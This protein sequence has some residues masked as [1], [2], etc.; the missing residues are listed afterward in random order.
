MNTD[1]E[2]VKLTIIVGGVLAVIGVDSILVIL[3]PKQ[4][5]EKLFL[6]GAAAY[7]LFS[8]SCLLISLTIILLYD[9]SPLLNQAFSE[10]RLIF[11]LLLLSLFF[12]GWTAVI[13]GC[14]YLQS[15]RCKAPVRTFLAYGGAIKFWVFILSATFFFILPDIH[16]I[17]LTLPEAVLII[18]GLPN[19]LFAIL[20]SKLLWMSRESGRES[21]KSRSL[22]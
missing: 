11:Q 18:A 9:Y 4:Q 20:F 8:G 22:G 2:T 6:L 5:Q 10:L 17:G 15:A 21:G 13:F 1:F 14:G 19:L 16:L 7:N 12:I 3:I